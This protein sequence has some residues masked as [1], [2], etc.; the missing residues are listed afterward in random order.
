MHV[1]SIGLRP[2]L[3]AI[4]SDSRK[5]R[6]VDQFVAWHPHLIAFYIT[7]ARLSI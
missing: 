3:G 4:V 1:D 2:G 5:A 7:P 6:R